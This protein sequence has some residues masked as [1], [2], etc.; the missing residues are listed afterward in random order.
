MNFSPAIA[1]VGIVGAACAY[2]LSKSIFTVEA[3][4]NGL[5]F[6]RFSGLK[7][8][9]LSEGWHLRIPYFEIPTIYDIRTRPRVI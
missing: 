6:S 4:S 9:R 8:I 5:L 7:D 2:L 3:G 1:K